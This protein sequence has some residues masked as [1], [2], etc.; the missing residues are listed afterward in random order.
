MLTTCVYKDCLY[1]L[2][3]EDTSTTALYRYTDPN[4][5]GIMSDVYYTKEFTHKANT[6]LRW[7][8]KPPLHYGDHKSYFTAA[9]N[10]KF[11]Q[12]CLLL[13]EAHIP[14]ILV[15]RFSEQEVGEIVYRDKYQVV[16]KAK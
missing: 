4:G 9:G 8:P 13:F 7:L 12:Q 10:E 16:V 14:A 15:T 6:A 2:A 3:A 11:V 5:V 1:R